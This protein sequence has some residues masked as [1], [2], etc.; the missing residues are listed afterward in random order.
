ML[1]PLHLTS[2]GGTSAPVW[3]PVSASTAATVYISDVKSNGTNAGTFTSGAWRTRDLNT[4]SDFGTGIT[5]SANQIIIPAG[6]WEIYSAAPAHD[7]NSNQA[8]L[9]NITDSSDTL[10]GQN[11]RTGSDSDSIAIVQGR[12]TIASQKTFEIQHQCQTTNATNGLGAACSFSV[13]EVYTQITIRKV[14]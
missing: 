12:F 1:I 9:V 4:I 5:I 6:T 13:G 3:A 10:I 14:T 11:A 7:V 2:A 8:K